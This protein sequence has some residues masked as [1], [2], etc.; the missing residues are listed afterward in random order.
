M[1][2]FNCLSS[3][4]CGKVVLFLVW[5]SFGASVQPQAAKHQEMPEKKLEE[6]KATPENCMRPEIKQVKFEPETGL[7]AH[8][9]LLVFFC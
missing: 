7:L 1:H 5:I 8:L 9:I 6:I 4:V 2:S 3:F